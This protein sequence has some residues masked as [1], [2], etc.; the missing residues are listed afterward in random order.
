[1]THSRISDD[2]LAHG[3]S[4]IAD[5]RRLSEAQAEND[6]ILS[7]T[8]SAGPADYI[9]PVRDLTWFGAIIVWSVIG[10]VIY[11]IWQLC[12]AMAS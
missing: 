5:A 6:A 3:W 7:D 12:E 8:R 4:P 10:A 1:M 11:V 2:V 9:G